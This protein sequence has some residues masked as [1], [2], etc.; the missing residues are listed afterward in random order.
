M[1]N[2]VDFPTIPDTF[3]Y[4]ILHYSYSLKTSPMKVLVLDN[5][6]SF[7]YNLVHM[8]EAIGADC[9]V[10]RNDQIED[11]HVTSHT[12]LVISPGP[13]LP[14]QAGRTMEILERYHDSH[15]IL[16]VCLG[17]QAI[18]EL[19]GARLKNLPRVFHGVSSPIEITN[20][21]ALF[22]GIPNHF[23][24]GRYHSWVIDAGT[25]PDELLVTAVDADGEIMAMQHNR[26]PIHSVQFHPESVMTPEGSKILKNWLLHTSI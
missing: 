25:M 23:Q 19:F 6:D 5:Y 17:H 2:C 10:V 24:A 26:L 15:A 1:T 20:E 8:L 13:G 4:T 21:S 3:A 18:G 7:T 16:G 12:R 11:H 9:E 14:S 22:D